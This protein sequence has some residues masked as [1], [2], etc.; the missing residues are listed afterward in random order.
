MD[1]NVLEYVIDFGFVPILTR[2]CSSQILVVS[3]WNELSIISPCAETLIMFPY[4]EFQKGFLI[5][6]FW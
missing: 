4:R 1:Y 2:C 5:E 3:P 6:F